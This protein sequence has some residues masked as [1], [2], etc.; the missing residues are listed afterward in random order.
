MIKRI[1]NFEMS[2]I[3]HSKPR[4]A[5]CEIPE[6][7]HIVKWLFE[8]SRIYSLIL[9]F[10]FPSERTT[11]ANATRF[12]CAF[13][14]QKEKSLKIQS[15][16]FDYCCGLCVECNFN[17]LEAMKADERAEHK[18][19]AKDLQSSDRTETKK[20]PESNINIIASRLD[21]F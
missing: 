10:N 16:L 21:V 5:L 3:Q 12:L 2:V 7:I 17:F 9:F 13:A 6:F 1:H 18:R 14:R 8:K 19:D 4:S 11:L 20:N 15:K